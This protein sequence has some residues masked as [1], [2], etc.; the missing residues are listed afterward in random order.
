MTKRILA[1]AA[2]ALLATTSVSFATT[3]TGS[4]SAVSSDQSNPYINY[5]PGTQLSYLS[6][7]FTENLTLNSTTTPTVF[8]D[9]VPRSG[10]GTMKGTIAVSFT[11]SDGSAV[12]G[13]TSTGNAATLSGS[14]I[15]VSAAYELF[16]GNQTDCI[17]W[18]S[19][20]GCTA[21]GD[22]TTIGDTIDATFADGAVV[23]IN[24]YNWSDWVMM[25]DISFELLDG[26]T[27]QGGQTPVPE[28][29]SLALLGTGL[30][31]LGFIRRHRHDAMK[32]ESLTSSL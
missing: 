27:P 2:V 12:T 3:I 15:D 11:L 24:L 7:P 20:T 6:S 30:A 26:P 9:V 32:G 16:Y 5:D 1:F 29:A 23:A 19:T 14:V 21:T 31:G 17:T 18:S 8:I 28:P 4:Y 22:T 10:S 25:P 13:V